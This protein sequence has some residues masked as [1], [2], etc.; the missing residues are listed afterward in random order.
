[1]KT[2]TCTGLNEEEFAEQLQ[3]T[4]RGER[5]KR[6]CYLCRRPEGTKGVSINEGADSEGIAVAEPEDVNDFETAPVIN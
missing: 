1:M 4:E 5:T 2:V 6:K 3:A